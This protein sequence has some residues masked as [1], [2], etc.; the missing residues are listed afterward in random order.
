MLPIV[1]LASVLRL[2][3]A[4]ATRHHAFVVGAGASA[5]ALL[6][7]RIVG[8]REIVFAR[9]PTRSSGWTASTGATDLGDG[10]AV[11]ILDAATNGA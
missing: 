11:L 8:Q 6:V 7:D 10:R 3:S 2:E 1:R 5:V 4:P 9:P